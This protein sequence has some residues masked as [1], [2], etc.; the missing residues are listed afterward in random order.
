MEE[1]REV[2]I[3]RFFQETV[4]NMSGTMR[5]DDSAQKHKIFCLSCLSVSDYL[6]SYSDD[7]FI[8]KKSAL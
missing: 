7:F 2:N 6:R 1:Y 8:I 5:G 3:S 4:Q